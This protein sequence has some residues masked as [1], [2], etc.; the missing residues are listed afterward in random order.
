MIARLTRIVA[1]LK[2]QRRAERQNENRIEHMME[3][4]VYC[5]VVLPFEAEKVGAYDEVF[6][7][8]D[9]VDRW[10]PF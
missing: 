10:L 4:C 7:S 8:A 6:C 5:N 3:R 9:C 2:A 1:N